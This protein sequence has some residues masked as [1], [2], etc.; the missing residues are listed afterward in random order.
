MSNDIFR[1]GTIL[2][3]IETDNVYRVISMNDDI[4]VLCEM[5]ITKFNVVRVSFKDILRLYENGLLATLSDTDLIFDYDSLSGDVK[6]RFDLRRKVVQEIDNVFGPTYFDLC[7]S[8]GNKALL[9]IKEKYQ[10]PKATFWRLIRKYYQSGM[11][12]SSL[13]DEKWLGQNKGK[14]YTQVKKMGAKPLYFIETGVV[15]TKEVEEYFEEALNEYLSGR[16]KT[17]KSAYTKMNLRHYTHVELIDGVKT[18]TL[19][20]ESQRPT[21]RQFRYYVSTHTTEQQIDRVKTSVQEQRNDKRLITS[22][23]LLDVYGPGDMCE[24]DAVEADVS[25]VS[26]LDPAK[27]VGRPVAY[28]MI[29]VFTRIIVAVSIAFDNNSMLGLSSLFLNLSD[30]KKVYCKKYG[31]ELK[32]ETVW[33]SNFIPARIRIDRGSDFKSK[34]F[35]RICNAL[36]IEKQLVSGGTGS[37]KGTVEQSFHQMH[38][39]QN[40]HLEDYG[41]IEKRHDSNHHKEASITIKDF[42]KMVINFVLFHNQQYDE[43]YPATREM[44]EKGVEPIPMKLWAYGV[45]KYGNPTPIVSLN[46]FYWE[47]MTPAK[48]KL[49]R[50]GI[51]YDGLWYLPQSDPQLSREMFKAGNTKQSFDIRIDKRDISSVYYMRDNTLVHAELNDMLTGNADYAGLTFKEYDDIRKNKKVMDAKGRVQNEDLE[52]SL[53]AADATVVKNGQSGIRASDKDMREN[54]KVQKQKT[55]YENRI[56]TRLEANEPESVIEKAETSQK[57]EEPK[58]SEK[59][60]SMEDDLLESA[61]EALTAFKSEELNY[62]GRKV[63]K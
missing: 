61:Q 18:A 13:L 53:Y 6:K 41:L 7:F 25:L 19:L 50:R 16:A 32:N 34:E 36:N 60:W 29:D 52:A 37:L 22:D 46:Q 30:D 2:K 27:T 31:I 28:F 17:M 10:M 42:T 39:K 21:L 54:R 4:V 59:K 11:K 57:L 9:N 38:S 45:K 26:E 55:S 14:T 5:N 43:T 48:A 33:P 44:I 51:S 63:K 58:P 1:V 24:I 23:A 35:N 15:R 12:Q 62:Y 20:P 47:L 49:S 3:N 8:R 40:V 56:A